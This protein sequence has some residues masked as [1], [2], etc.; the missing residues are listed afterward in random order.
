LGRGEGR[1]ARG[2]VA[3]AL[4]IYRKLAERG[5]A[6]AQD[7]LGVLYETGRGVTKSYAEA[8]SGIA[9]PPTRVMPTRRTTWG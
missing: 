6:R 2:D 1:T 5:D 9:G 8:A 3:T 7:K 4:A